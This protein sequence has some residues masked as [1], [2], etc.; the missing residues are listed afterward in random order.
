ME[1]LLLKSLNKKH[2]I[3]VFFIYL[4]FILLSITGHCW[5][6]QQ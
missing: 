4:F 2:Y 1:S 6:T 3:Y 5:A